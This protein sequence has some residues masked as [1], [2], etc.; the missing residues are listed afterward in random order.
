MDR[1]FHVLIYCLLVFIWKVWVCIWSLT[2]KLYHV[3]SILAFVFIYCLSRASVTARD[4][5]F[6]P[7]QVIPGIYSLAHAQRFSASQEH[8]SDFRVS[9]AYL[10]GFIV[11]Y[12]SSVICDV[13][14]LLFILLIRCT[15]AKDSL[16]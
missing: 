15:Q 4:E 13:R 6:R 12:S 8:I 9:Y 14:Q 3:I 10:F 16:Q 2:L 1:C 5:S 11:E 7:C